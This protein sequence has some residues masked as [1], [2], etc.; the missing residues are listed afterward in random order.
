MQLVEQHIIQKG[1]PRWAELDVLGFTAKNLYNL[2]NYHI[3]QAYFKTRKTLGWGKLDKLL[4]KTDAYQA[5]PAKVAQLVIKSV[6]DCWSS[7]FEAHKAWQL[8]PKKFKAEPK[9]PRYKHKEKGRYVLTYNLQAIGKRERR[10]GII[11]LSKTNIRFFSKH[12]RRACQVRIIPQASHYTIEL[13]YEKPVHT[14]KPTVAPLPSRLASLDIGVDNLAAIVYNQPGT[15]P[16]LVNGRPLKSINQFYY[17]EYARLISL[18]AVEN[19]TGDHK[20]D[21]KHSHQL[22]KLT[23]KRNHKVN[24]YLHGAS[25]FIVDE[26]VKQ[27]VGVLVIGQ[28]DGWKQEINLGKQTNQNFVSIPHARFIEMIVYKTK[29]VGI[30]VIL[31]EESYTSKCSFLDNEPLEHQESYAGRRVKR[32]LFRSAKGVFLNA[33]INGAANIMRKAIP[34]AFAEGIEAVVVRPLRVTPHQGASR[35]VRQAASPIPLPMPTRNRAMSQ[36]SMF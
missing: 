4:Q 9:I 18:L 5:L 34:N 21:R 26:L 33:D 11:S 2:T 15:Q 22:D 17:Q 31:Q 6:T 10:K 16:F 8:E 27:K 28:N 32:G 14:H 20:L 7:Y 29:L 12:T 19:K 13:V 25:R 1:D 30:K 35:Q 36:L 3:R 24:H 23:T